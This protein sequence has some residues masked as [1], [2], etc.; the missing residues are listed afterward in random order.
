MSD[1]RKQTVIGLKLG[2]EFTIERRFS[3]EEVAA[4][5]AIS[6]DDNPIHS[7]QDFIASKGMKAP[8]CHGL[9]V[10][11]ILTEIGGQIGWLAS[12]MNLKFIRPAYVNE[13]IRCIFRLE[14]IDSKNRAMARVTFLNLENKTVLKA[15]LKGILP[16]D[17][18]RQILEQLL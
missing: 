4:F 10:A 5:A 7:N 16:S 18:E 13:S 1:I 17:S 8:I 9:L 14:K 12:E 3:A 11:S 15:T 6:K 2:Q